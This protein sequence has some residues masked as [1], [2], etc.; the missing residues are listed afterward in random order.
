MPKKLSIGNTVIT[1]IGF[2]GVKVEYNKHSICID[3]ASEVENCSIILYTHSHSRHYTNSPVSSEKRVYSP[4]TGVIVKPGDV[5]EVEGI[6]I[7]V[8]EAYNDPSIHGDIVPHPRGF[9]VG[10]ILSPPEG[11]SIYYVGD[12]DLVPEL[13]QVESSIDVLIPPIGGGAVMNPEDAFELVKS[14]KPVVTIPVHTEDPRLLY[15]FR[16]MVQPYTQVVLLWK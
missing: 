5:L 12:S 7:T 16:D 13:I 3:P 2:A 10:Y 9:S 14:I 8:R 1:R 15:K 6:R 11:P 4:F